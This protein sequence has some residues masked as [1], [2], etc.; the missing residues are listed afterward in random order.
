MIIFHLL[1]LE[2]IWKENFPRRSIIRLHSAFCV[3][4][5]GTHLCNQSKTRCHRMS[6]GC[7][8]CYRNVK[9]CIVL[10]PNCKVACFI[11]NFASTNY[12]IASNIFAIH[13]WFIINLLQIQNKS[14]L[15]ENLKA[16]LIHSIPSTSQFHL[17]KIN[18]C[19]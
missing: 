14:K 2:S 7:K 16:A 12:G 18:W 15:I 19:H 1:D 11:S 6:N 4:Y 9:K 5:K 3:V 13:L 8:L 10:P 17:F